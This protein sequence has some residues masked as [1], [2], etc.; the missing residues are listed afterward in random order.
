MRAPSSGAKLACVIVV[1]EARWVWQDRRWAHL[2]STT[3]IA[4]LHDF[5]EAIGKRRVG[6]QGDHYDV[7]EAERERALAAGAVPTSSRE[8]V[9]ALRAAGLRRSAA[10]PKLGHALTERC[11]LA[12][13]GNLLS[14]SRCLSRQPRAALGAAAAS[15]FSQ[16]FAPVGHHTVR[17][18]VLTRP[19]F[20]AAVVTLEDAAAVGLLS[21]L[22]GR[23]RQAGEA[24]GIN[25]LRAPATEQVGW[26]ELLWEAAR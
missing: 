7:D 2:C 12:H 25:E 15:V 10:K 4:E 5:A 3:D 20:A 18:D 9:R 19:D 1:D 6:F 22:G 14:A 13:V 17:L 24:L 21:P 11:Q 16:H 26:V 23:A 8:I